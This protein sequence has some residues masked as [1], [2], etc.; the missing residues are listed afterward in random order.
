MYG[1]YFREFNMKMDSVGYQK[2]RGRISEV[3]QDIFWNLELDHSFAY[4]YFF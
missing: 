3:C 2:N 1:V 4:L